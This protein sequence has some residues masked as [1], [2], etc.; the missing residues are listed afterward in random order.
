MRLL[1]SMSCVFVLSSLCPR[2]AEAQPPPERV[3]VQGKVTDR[4]TGAPVPNA[5]VILKPLPTVGIERQTW[6]NS[7]A[8]TNDEGTFTLEKVEEGDYELTVIVR[9]YQ[10]H[11]QPCVRVCASRT[12]PLDVALEKGNPFQMPLPRRPPFP[13]GD[14][15]LDVGDLP[16]EILEEI[17]RAGR[18]IFGDENGVLRAPRILNGVPLGTGRG[19]NLP[20]LRP[21]RLN[22]AD[23]PI[24]TFNLPPH[25]PRTAG[26][27]FQIVSDE[28]V[29]VVRMAV[30]DVAQI[31][32]R[33]KV[34]MLKPG[35]GQ[36]QG[37]HL[38]LMG[39]VNISLLR[40]GKIIVNVQAPRAT[41]YEDAQ[42]IVV[43]VRAAR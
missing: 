9:G 27:L 2:P 4:Q 5:K 26:R 34:S 40:D 42:R 38:E 36:G 1:G 16:A 35:A 11:W 24:I 10:R 6:L 3:M 43:D 39:N 14:W 25:P 13:F 15:A 41:L 28:R 30:D 23:R 31:D 29:D 12:S 22:R 7:E 19:M 20:T 18:L 37:K 21:P 33:T 8:I 32:A 17:R